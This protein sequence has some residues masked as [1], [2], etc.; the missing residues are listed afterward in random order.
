MWLVVAGSLR[1]LPHRT[2]AVCEILEVETYQVE[3][4]APQYIYIDCKE[5]LGWLNTDSRIFGW[6][7]QEDCDDG[8]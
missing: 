4:G 8:F 3:T 6:F 2:E 1:T 7:P 5:E